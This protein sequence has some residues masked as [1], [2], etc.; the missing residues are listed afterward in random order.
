M[1]SLEARQAKILQPRD[2]GLREAGVGDVGQRRAAPQLQRAL[3]VAAA[4]HGSPAPSSARPQ[5]TS[6]SKR[7][8]SSSPG[9]SRSA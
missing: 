1:R 9:A 8:A 4:S 5:R 6:P 3:S 2:L 7:S